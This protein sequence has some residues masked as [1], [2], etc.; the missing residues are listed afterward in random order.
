MMP[1][2][3]ADRMIPRMMPNVEKCQSAF[4]SSRLQELFLANFQGFGLAT[5][6]LL[7]LP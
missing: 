4:Q 2:Q 3:L 1:R 7:R 5:L 6:V